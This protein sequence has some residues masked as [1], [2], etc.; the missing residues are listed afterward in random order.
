M[1]LQRET[2][3]RRGTA[4][5]KERLTP[6][7]RTPDGETAESSPGKYTRHQPQPQNLH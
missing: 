6:G 7:A 3:E 5:C 1:G 4:V 2:L